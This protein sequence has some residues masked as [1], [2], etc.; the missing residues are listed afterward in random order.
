M[1][2]NWE[3]YRYRWPDPLARQGALAN[4]THH[5]WSKTR[6]GRLLVIVVDKIDI[7]ENDDDLQRIVTFV[8]PFNFPR[9]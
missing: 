6:R 7:L 9:I 3:N 2:L 5:I 4:R 1:Y 8:Y